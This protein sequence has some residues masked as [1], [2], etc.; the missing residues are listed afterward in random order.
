MSDICKLLI[1][2]ISDLSCYCWLLLSGYFGPGKTDPSTLPIRYFF[3]FAT[4]TT[5]LGN[6]SLLIAPGSS[7]PDRH[8]R[9]PPGV[10]LP[11]AQTQ[12]LKQTTVC[13]RMDPTQ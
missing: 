12:G 1:L 3:L 5:D 11:Q 13:A 2:L 4:T 9:A 8:R 7:I 6:P 10:K